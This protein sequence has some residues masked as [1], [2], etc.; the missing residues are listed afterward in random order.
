MVVRFG[1]DIFATALCTDLAILLHI[2]HIR[3]G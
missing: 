3:S 1:G 2:C